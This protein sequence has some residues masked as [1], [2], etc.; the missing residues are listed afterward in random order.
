MKGRT[1]TTRLAS[2][3][4]AAGLVFLPSGVAHAGPG[5]GGQGAVQVDPPITPG[6]GWSSTLAT[7]PAFF[8]GPTNSF[9][10]EGPF[11]FSSATPAVVSVT[12]DFNQGDQFRVFDN[13]VVLGDTNPV[14]PGNGGEVGPVAAFSDPAYSHG[15]F[16]VGAGS[17]SITIQA[18][19]SPFG[20]GRGYIRVD[21]CTVF[22]SGDLTGTEGPDV[23]CGSA[24]ADRI[25]ALGGDDLIFAFG[26]DDQI[27]AGAG[28]DTVYAGSGNDRIAGGDGDDLLDGQ[29]GNDQIIG[30]AGTDTLYGGN[31]TDGCLQGETVRTC[32]P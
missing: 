29:D 26:G 13:S 17:H 16:L 4:F 5:N 10:S 21:V 28:N 1:A 7:P 6:A 31:G 19:A 18:I 32:E 12:D 30:G 22:G 15:S 20:G 27:A 23:I 11:T 24:G 8:F 3:L 25:A 9:N 2:A 14:P